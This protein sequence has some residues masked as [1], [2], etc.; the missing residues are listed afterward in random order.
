MMPMSA[1]EIQ[2]EARDHAVSSV[3]PI[4]RIHRTNIL[5]PQRSVAALVII[6]SVAWYCSLPIDDRTMNGRSRQSSW[7]ALAPRKAG[8]RIPKNAAESWRQIEKRH[9]EKIH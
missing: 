7:W 1:C 8:T 6:R 9:I 2:N 3:V 4:P 5:R